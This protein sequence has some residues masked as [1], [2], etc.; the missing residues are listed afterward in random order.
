MESKKKSST[1]ENPIED[2][3]K[4]NLE[5]SVNHH[6]HPVGIIIQ[7]IISLPHYTEGLSRKIMRITSDDLGV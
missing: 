7:I 6:V 5:L 3:E 1:G 4:S 2:F